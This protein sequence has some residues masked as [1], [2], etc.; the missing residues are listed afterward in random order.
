M[1]GKIFYPFGEALKGCRL[2]SSLKEILSCEEALQLYR[3]EFKKYWDEGYSL[4]IGT[5][6][7]DLVASDST[8]IHV[9]ELLDQ[10]PWNQRSDEGGKKN[11]SSGSNDD[12][13][14]VLKYRS[15]RVQ[16]LISWWH[17]CCMKKMSFSKFLEIEMTEYVERGSR[18]IDSLQ[19]VERFTDRGLNVVLIDLSGVMEKGYDLSNVIACDIMKV[20]C[21]ENKIIEGEADDPLIKNQKKG[22][23]FGGVSEEQINEIEKIIRERDCSFRHLVGNNKL[24]ILYP[25]DLLDVFQSCG[26]NSG[27]S[28]EVMTQRI[29]NIIKPEKDIVG[30][31]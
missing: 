24:K 11:I 18:I 23:D 6:A 4:V 25:K 15:P 17:Q 12:V 9:D 19:V 14:V 3:N 30:A 2:R 10:M 21:T 22:G 20:P 28:R 29:Y 7:F 1:H 5:E 31:E 16:H 27:I 8:P 26:E 13:T